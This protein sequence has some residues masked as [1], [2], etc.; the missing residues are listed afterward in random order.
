MKTAM[1]PLPYG[2]RGGQVRTTLIRESVVP[3]ADQKTL[4]TPDRVEEWMRGVVAEDPEFNPDVETLW[5]IFLTTRRKPMGVEKLATGTLDTIL[6]HPRE[7]FRPAIMQAASA[8]VL[9]HNHP[10]GETQP[11]EGDIRFTRTIQKA[12]QMLSLE[13]LDHVVIATE[14]RAPTN[15]VRR[16]SSLREL[17]YFYE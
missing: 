12:G 6:I 13:V 16:Y 14:G 5:V 10:S 3:W 1:R 4:D 15:A 8:V 7:V 17:G 2:M 9:V 11:S